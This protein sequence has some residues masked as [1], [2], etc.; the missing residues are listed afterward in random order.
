MKLFLGE[1]GSAIADIDFDVPDDVE[2]GGL[3]SAQ[4]CD[5]ARYRAWEF[6]ADD[7]A[8]IEEISY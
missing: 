8:M 1:G 4:T 5:G 2:T 3:N 6:D 7:R